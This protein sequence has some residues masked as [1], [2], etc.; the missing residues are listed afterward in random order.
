VLGVTAQNFAKVEPKQ[1]PPHL[2][3]ARPRAKHEELTF[4]AGATVVFSICN[5]PFRTL[6][7]PSGRL[8]SREGLRTANPQAKDKRKE[9]EKGSE[10][11]KRKHTHIVTKNDLYPPNYQPI[12]AT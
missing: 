7:L 12:L 3:V 6:G 2:N 8:W 10:E 1:I 9:K 5:K 11:K 4:F